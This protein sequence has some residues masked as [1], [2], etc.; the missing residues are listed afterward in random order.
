VVLIGARSELPYVQ[1]LFDRFPTEVQARVANTAG[2]L[3]L[4]EMLVMLDGAACVLTNDSGPMHKAVALERP[5]VCLFGPANP[6][7]YGQELPYV[8][9]FYAPV[10]CSPC[11]YETD[12]PPCYGNNVCM[13]RIKPEPWCKRYCGCSAPRM[14][15]HK[16]QR[17]RLISQSS[18]M[19]R[20]AGRWAW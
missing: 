6:G 8:S 3:T 13:Q 14:P 18:V 9:I 5:T 10:F 16:Y 17:G 11:L 15:V 12:Q 2:R 20:T 4:G 7:H 1:S 19:R